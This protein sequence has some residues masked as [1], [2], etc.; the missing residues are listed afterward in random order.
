M[1]GL[2]DDGNGH[3]NPCPEGIHK[4]TREQQ[5]LAQRPLWGLREHRQYLNLLGGREWGRRKGGETQRRQRLHQLTRYTG[6]G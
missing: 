6:E 5:V 1:S 3:N 4:S 2:W